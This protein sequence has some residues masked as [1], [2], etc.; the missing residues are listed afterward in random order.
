LR[1]GL[2]LLACLGAAVSLAGCC[3]TGTHDYVIDAPDPDLA[4]ALETCVDSDC[5]G[6]GCSSLDCRG[7]CTRVAAL[8]GDTIAQSDFQWCSITGSVDGGAAVQVAI[9][10]STCGH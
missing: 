7:A 9:H 8:A 3:E 2:A 5:H 6:T 1:I 4:A 10:Y